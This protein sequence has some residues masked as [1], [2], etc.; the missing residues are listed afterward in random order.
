MLRVWHSIRNDPEAF[1]FTFTDQNSKD[2]H[3]LPDAFHG[4][5][6]PGQFCGNPAAII[7]GKEA[8]IL[9]RGSKRLAT[10]VAPLNKRG[11]DLT[12]QG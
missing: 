9:R 2:T 7:E 10:W 6:M 4:V 12:P 1:T 3:R 11:V 8:L 5:T